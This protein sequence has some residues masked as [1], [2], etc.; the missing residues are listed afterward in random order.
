MTGL[1]RRLELPEE[2][3][4]NLINLDAKI[5]WLHPAKSCTLVWRPAPDFKRQRQGKDSRSRI[6]G[7]AFGLT[8][9]RL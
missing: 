6:M 2:N 5:P 3:D 7:K 9:E 1:W 8:P 4:T